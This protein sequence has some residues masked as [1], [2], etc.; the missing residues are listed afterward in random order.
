MNLILVI[1]LLEFKG[2]GLMGIH[3]RK[4][5]IK[6]LYPPQIIKILL[7]LELM[8]EMAITNLTLRTF[9]KSILEVQNLRK[10]KFLHQIGIEAREK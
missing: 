6:P 5:L 2:L 7:K 3:L 1:S 8:K 10:T 9:S 4:M